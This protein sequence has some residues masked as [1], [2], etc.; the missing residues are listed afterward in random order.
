MKTTNKTATTKTPRTSTRVAAAKKTPAPTAKTKKSPEPLTSPRVTKA[1][2]NAKKALTLA[3]PEVTKSPKPTTA[4]KKPRAIAR[5]KPDTTP[6]SQAT[7]VVPQPRTTIE[8]FIDVGFD[9]LPRQCRVG[10][11][12]R[13]QRGSSARLQIPA[14]RRTLERRR[15]L[16]TRPRQNRCLH[17]RVLR[18]KC[19][20]DKAVTDRNHYAWGGD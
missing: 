15:K 8:A 10:H 13:R 6:A 16:H 11:H 20:A 3:T 5:P 17:A 1:A 9:E 4:A 14:Q 7:A 18:Y 2:A 12:A 19:D